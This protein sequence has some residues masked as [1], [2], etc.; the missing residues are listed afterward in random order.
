MTPTPIPPTP[1][2]HWSGGGNFG[3]SGGGSHGFGDI[4]QTPTPWATSPNEPYELGVPMD[5][6]PMQVVQGYNFVNQQGGLDLLWFIM[7][8]AL[9]VGGLASVYKRL[10]RL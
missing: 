7:I 4:W 9:I 8:I 2:P 10:Q 3:G 5:A 6:V 1:T